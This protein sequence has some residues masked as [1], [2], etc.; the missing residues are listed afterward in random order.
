MTSGR[1]LKNRGLNSRDMYDVLPPTRKYTDQEAKTLLA[2]VGID[3]GL[4]IEV[5]DTGVQKEYAGTFFSGSVSGN[6]T[7]ATFS[8][9]SSPTYRY[10]RQTAFRA[11]LLEVRTGRSLWVGDGQA[12]AGGLLF[13]GD[14]ANAATTVSGYCSEHLPS[15]ASGP[16]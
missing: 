11:K 13:I 8:G 5:G 6:P 4:V 15:C 1:G 10:S 12:R 9:S 7:F 14:G 16:A 3:A 2:K